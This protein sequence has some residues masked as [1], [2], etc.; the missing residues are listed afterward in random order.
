MLEV[1]K[2]I[3]NV[4]ST[5]TPFMIPVQAAY[6]NAEITKLVIDS[7]KSLKNQ[8]IQTCISTNWC[9]HTKNI[10]LGKEP[11]TFQDANNLAIALWRRKNPEGVSLKPK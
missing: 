9:L 10:V 5:A 8:L 6:T 2:L 4:G 3:K 7:N 11:A 1:S